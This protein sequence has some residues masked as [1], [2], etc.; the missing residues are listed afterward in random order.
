MMEHNLEQQQV[1]PTK[2]LM[3]AIVTYSFMLTHKKIKRKKKKKEA[4]KAFSQTP[5]LVKKLVSI[6]QCSYL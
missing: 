6:Y 4:L 2:V 3:N 1:I 5:L